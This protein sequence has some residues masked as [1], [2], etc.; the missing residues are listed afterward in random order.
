MCFAKESEIFG[1]YWSYFSSG[2][3]LGRQVGA[4]TEG[5]YELLLPGKFN[6]ERQDVR[7]VFL[8]LLVFIE[9][10]AGSLG[11]EAQVCHLSI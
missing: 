2:R 1:F 8:V 6:R 9:R 11:M 3:C 4:D 7:S 10:T 5:I